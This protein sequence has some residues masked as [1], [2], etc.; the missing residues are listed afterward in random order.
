VVACLICVLA[1]PLASCASDGSESEPQGGAALDAEM[2]KDVVRPEPIVLERYELPDP[3]LTKPSR[4]ATFRLAVD[5]FAAEPGVHRVE[6]EGL[7]GAVG[8]RATHKVAERE[9]AGWNERY[10][11]KGAF[12]LRYEDSF[13]YGGG[14]ALLLLPTT[15]DLEAVDAA[16]TD[17]VNL[18]ISHQEVMRW[19]RELMG[20]H[21]F[22]VTGAG[23][24]FV[25]GRF[26]EPPADTR[27]LAKEMYRFCPDIVDQG[28]GTVAALAKELEGGLLYLWWD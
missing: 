19:L 20:T 7:P 13:G 2:L 11:H 26:L 28:T 24:D 15:D 17:G 16:G 22:R 4:K 21:P 3:G 18:D 14:D 12:V 9:L 23:I 10:R 8:F 5:A 25:E 27:A 1:L 6:V